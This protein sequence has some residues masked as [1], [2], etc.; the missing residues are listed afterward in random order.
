MGFQRRNS[1][2]PLDPSGL[3][4]LGGAPVKKESISNPQTKKTDAAEERL[5]SDKREIGKPKEREKEGKRVEKRTSPQKKAD[6]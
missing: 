3:F 1:K 5:E 6:A 4:E 2:D